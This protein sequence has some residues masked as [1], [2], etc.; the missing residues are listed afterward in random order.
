MTI[1]LKFDQHLL[2]LYVGSDLDTP[3]FVYDE[4]AIIAGLESLA[5]IRHN[6]G[7]RMLYSIKA[8]SF[9]LLLER[10]SRYVDGFSVSSLFE[11][12]LACEVLGR[13]DEIH[14][15]CPGLNEYEIKEVAE[16]CGFVSFNSLAQWQRCRALS[17]R[18]NCGLRINPELSFL[19]DERYDP[20]RP[21]SKLGV[22]LSQLTSLVNLTERLQG[23]KGFHFHNN[24]D[25]E[26]FR[27]LELTVNKLVQGLGNMMPELEW[28]NLGGGYRF[29]NAAGLKVLGD[30]AGGLRKNHGFDVFFEPGR[31]VVENAGYLVA[32]V[33][34]IFDSG[35]RTIALLDT[36]IN[37]MPEVFEYQIK[38][39]V[40]QESPQG[41]Y[42]YRLAGASCLSGDLFGDYC[43]DE[44]LE[45]NNRIIFTQAGAYTTVKAFR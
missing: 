40:L 29:S 16:T 26:N 32:S 2:P 22:P 43:F 15:T 13:R 37:H 35:A 45:V 1:A 17:A 31:A 27:E 8:S 7:C 9:S 14:L 6:S 24:C 11:G 10:I 25:S 41:R 12:R 18:V 44:P 34:D 23:I 5:E 42:I 33:V 39:R 19:P 3:A 20:C 38:P 28:I 36:T 30:I 21:D 4:A